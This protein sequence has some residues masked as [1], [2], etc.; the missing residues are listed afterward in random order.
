MACLKFGFMLLN[1]TSLISFYCPAG[2]V[3]EGMSERG[4]C[5]GATIYPFSDTFKSC[6]VQM[7]STY[8]EPLKS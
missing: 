6:L 4:S 1:P 7:I 5:A 3:H 2:Y 8:V